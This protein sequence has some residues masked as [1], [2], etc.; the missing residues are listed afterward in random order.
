MQDFI[1]SFCFFF[2]LDSNGLSCNT[3]QT[4]LCGYDMRSDHHRST[5]K[6]DFA[7]A[8]SLSLFRLHLQHGIHDRN[9]CLFSMMEMP[10]RPRSKV[11]T[12]YVSEA[13]ITAQRQYDEV[14][15]RGGDCHTLAHFF[16]DPLFWDVSVAQAWRVHNLQRPFPSVKHPMVNSLPLPTCSFISRLIC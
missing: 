6:T 9:V 15:T 4:D 10:L 8:D 1:L 16:V 13:T 14:G 2:G 11:T 7:I 5:L 3:D 12:T